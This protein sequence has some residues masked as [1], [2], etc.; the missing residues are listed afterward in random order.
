MS[1]NTSGSVTSPVPTLSTRTCSTHQCSSPACSLSH[2]SMPMR[3]PAFLQS[4]SP[5]N[6][7]S[8]PPFSHTPPR[9]TDIAFISWR[10]SIAKLPS[11]CSST[12][13]PPRTAGTLRAASPRT[14]HP[15]CMTRAEQ[16]PAMPRGIRSARYITDAT[17]VD[18]WSAMTGEH[19]QPSLAYLSY[20][21]CQIWTFWSRPAASSFLT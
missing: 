9:R 5:L 17:T 3:R 6:S 2:D 13:A 14:G 21:F 16:S 11:H 10:P 4:D 19:R 7:R 18:S 1:M 8:V 15:S 20:H 12:A